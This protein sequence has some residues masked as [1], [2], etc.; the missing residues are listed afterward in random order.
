[1]GF[2][3]EDNPGH[4]LDGGRGCDERRCG[5]QKAGWPF[6]DKR[7]KGGTDTEHDVVPTCSEEAC[8]DRSSDG[9]NPDDGDDT[10]WHIFLSNT[11]FFLDPSWHNGSD[12]TLA[13]SGA[14]LNGYS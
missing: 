2:G 13:V 4:R 8:S 7:L 10:H 12:L 11:A 3:S 1:M 9:S 6:N 5:P 14:P